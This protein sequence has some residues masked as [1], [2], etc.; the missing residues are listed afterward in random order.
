MTDFKI[1][2]GADKESFET[3]VNRLLNEDYV[4]AGNIAHTPNDPAVWSMPMIKLSEKD[5][6]SR[7]AKQLWGLFIARLF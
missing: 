2:V 1:A 7:L 6:D 3:E 4:F 5:V